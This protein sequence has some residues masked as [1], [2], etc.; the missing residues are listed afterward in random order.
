MSASLQL[1]GGLEL[2]RNLGLLDKR[3]RSRAITKA[4]RKAA[5]PVIKTSKGLV[6]RDTGLLRLSLGQ[7]VRTDRRRGQTYSVVG[8]RLHIA[9]KKAAAIRG[10]LTRARVP[11]NYADL[12]ELGTRHSRPRPFLRP[13]F[14]AHVKQM[15]RKMGDV[16][17]TEIRKVRA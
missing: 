4:V 3:V 11:A 17:W 14:E 2:E 10:G 12:V 6:P 13:A 8:A 5:Q 9:G 15:P 16:L 1:R 7:K